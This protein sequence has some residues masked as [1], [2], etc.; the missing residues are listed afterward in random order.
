M[1]EEY[2]IVNPSH[3]KYAG[4][5]EHCKVAEDWKLGAQLYN[6]TRYICRVGRKP[7]TDS[8]KELEKACWY[9]ERF[10]WLVR[11]KDWD[12][13]FTSPCKKLDSADVCVAWQLPLNLALAVMR[14]GDCYRLEDV[15]MLEDALHFV[16]EHIVLLP[17]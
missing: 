16:K 17:R 11:E 8:I 1:A 9:L 5:Y 2:D 13:G 14:I 10:I 6:A 15:S 3:Y 4:D 12:I 7:G